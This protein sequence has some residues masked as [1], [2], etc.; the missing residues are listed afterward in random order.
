M[1]LKYDTAPTGTLTGSNLSGGWIVKNDVA[2]KRILLRVLC[3]RSAWGEEKVHLGIGCI[4][5]GNQMYGLRDAG[6]ESC[7]DRINAI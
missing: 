4:G 2:N 7:R 3:R 6:G 1:I 5:M